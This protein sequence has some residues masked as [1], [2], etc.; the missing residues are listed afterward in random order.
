AMPL[1]IEPWDTSGVFWRFWGEEGASDVALCLHGVES[2]SAWFEEVAVCLVEK[3]WACVAFDRPGWGRSAGERGHLAS[4]REALRQVVS[5]AA[6]L[7]RHFTRVHLV[8]LSWGGMLA[9]YTA[10]RR[11]IFFDSLT[12]IAPGIWPAVRLP[13][14]SILR[15]AAAL[16]ARAPQRRVA[17][18]IDVSWFTRRKDRSAYIQRDPQRVTEVT[19]SFCLETLK[20]RRFIAEHLPLRQVRKGCALLAGDDRIVDN[21]ATERSLRP[22]GLAISLFAGAAHSLVFESPARVA[23]EIIA[24]GSRSPGAQGVRVLIAGA[25]AVGGLTAGLLAL[26]GERVTL[27]ARPAQAQAIAANGLRLVMPEGERQVGEV[28]A[29]ADA[30]AVDS[31]PDLVVLAVKSF[32]TAAALAELRPAIGPNAGFLSLQNGIDNEALIAAAYPQHPVWAGAICA[33]SIATE[34]G[35]ICWLDDRGGLALAPVDSMA[36][37]GAGD[38]EKLLRLWRGTGMEAQMVLTEGAAA[39]IKWSK[40][41]LNVAFN[42]LNAATGLSAAEILAHPECGALAA[43]ALQEGFTV[44]R[45]QGIK[46]IDLPGYP[47]SHLAWLCQLPAPLLRR[48]LAWLLRHEPSG[49]SSMRQ[50]IVAGRGQTEAIFINGAIVKAGQRLNIPTPANVRLWQWVDSLRDHQKD[51]SFRESG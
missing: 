10:L 38:S 23:E 24:N 6:A 14:W 12:L 3:K 45:A 29:V 49:M 20:M 26:A 44:M 32:A 37:S 30:S 16:A 8:G 4:Y 48:A 17:L 43:Q 2:H 40:L 34:P 7:R 36:L 11:G 18:P 39:R 15:L 28:E 27:L 22:A 51:G 13:W 21:A 25:G 31:A 46:P 5:G 47:V 35:R 33:Y 1:A 50:D 19:A 41:M 9:L 42:A